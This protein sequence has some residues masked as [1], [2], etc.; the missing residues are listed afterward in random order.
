MH[1]RSSFLFSSQAPCSRPLWAPGG[2][3]T[4]LTVVRPLDSCAVEPLELPHFPPMPT[5]PVPARIAIAAAMVLLGVSGADAGDILRGGTPLGGRSGGGKGTAGPVNAAAEAARINAKDAL[6]RTT[7]A[8]ASVRAMQNAARTAALKAP[9]NL[10]INP[11]IPGRPLPN[12]ADGLAENGLKVAAGVPRK[13]G[14]PKAG[15]DPKLWRGAALPT[16]SKRDGRVNVTVFQTSSQ[17]V[18][19]WETFNVGKKT[20]L[21]FNQDRGGADKTQWTAFNK[22]ADPSGAPSQILGKIE[23]PGQVYVINPNG[24]MFGGSAQINL[25]GLVASSLP[26]NEGLI[27]RGLLSN[28]DSQFLF[29]A[30]PQAAGKNGTPAHTPV[31]SLA[32]GGKYGDVVVQKGAQISAPSSSNVGGR[33][34][35]VGPNVK[36]EGTISTPDGQT[37][38]AAGLQV[39]ITAHPSSDARLRGLD[40]WVGAVNV[41]K[42]AA[43]DAPPIIPAQN[44]AGTAT[45][46]GLIEAARGNTTIAGRTVNQLGAI[47]SSTS[48]SVNGS[49][50]LHANFAAT[51]IAPVNGDA[52][53]SH[54]NT[55]TVTM[56]DDSVQ[57]I[58]PELFNE[59]TVIGLE[60]S[61]R[62]RVTVQGRNI[63]MGR[64]STLLAP[65]ADVT[66]AAGQWLTVG[67]SRQFFSST[68]QIYLDSGAL[69]NVAGTTDVVVP[70]SQNILSLELRGAELAD[71]PLQRRG[72]LRGP[73]LN[74]DIRQR[75]NYN[76]IDWVGTP[77]GNAVGYVGLIERNVGELTT[78]GGTVSMNAGNSVVIQKGAKVDVSG[79]YVNFEGGTVATTRIISDGRVVDIANALPDRVHTRLYD[80]AFTVANPKYG[81]E[82]TFEHPLAL[83]GEHFEPGYIEGKNAGSV[84][85]TAPS[86]VLDGELVGKTISG[87][88]QRTAALAPKLGA[89]ALTF[90]KPDAGIVNYR[91][92]SPTPPA[93]SFGT[94]SLPEA[95]AFSVNAAG[96]APLLDPAR[97][98]KVILPQDLFTNFGSVTINNGDGTLEVPEETKLKLQP[99]GTFA[100]TASNIEIRSDI[101]APGGTLNFTALKITPYLD[102]LLNDNQRSFLIRDFD[103]TRGRFYLEKGVRLDVAGLVV[104]DR[105]LSSEPLS[106]PIATDGGNISI[107]GFKVD[108]EKGSVLDASGGVVFDRSG[109]RTYG[110]GGSISI[111]GG[112]DPRLAH[113]LNGYVI[114]ERVTDPDPTDNVIPP[115]RTFT[116]SGAG[117]NLGA[118]LRAFSGGRGG[119][120][121]IQA[122][123]I[124][125]G[126]ETP[127]AETTLALTPEFFSKGGF[128]SFSLTGLGEPLKDG[129]AAGITVAPGTIIKPTAKSTLAVPYG[130]SREGAE[131]MEIL[132]P[133]ALRTPVSITLRAPG[134]RDSGTLVTRGDVVIGRGATIETDPRGAITIAGETVD[135][136]GSL[137]APAGVISV[138]GSSNPGV[139]FNDSGKS[140]TSV[141]IG[142]DAVLSAKGTT[143]YT[144]NPF[145]FR[146]GSVLPGGR[147]SVSGNIVAEAG[148]ILDVSGATGILDLAPAFVNP[149]PEVSFTSVVPMNSGVNAPLY[150]QT[151]VPT[152]V[153]S[154]AGEIVIAGGQHLF[155]DATLLGKAGGP[156]ALGGALTIS[157]GRFY[158]AGVISNPTDVTLKVTQARPTIPVGGSPAIGQAVSSASGVGH[159]A[160][161]SFARGGFDSLTLRG[162]V[163]FLGP[164]K[165]DARRTLTVADSGV[166]YANDAVTLKAPYITLGTPFKP[167]LTE[168]QV[169]VPYLD[170]NGQPYKFSP[171]SGTGS[172]TVIGNLIDIGNLAL[173]N[174]GKTSF[175]AD[176]GDIRGNGTLNAA[177]DIHFRAGQIYTPTS[178]TF[179]IAA[180]DYKLG[181]ETIR[182]SVVIEGSGNR[183]IPLSAGGTLNVYASNIVQGGALRVPLGSINI[184]WNGDGTAPINPVT[185]EAFAKAEKITLAPG[186]ITS[187]SAISPVEGAPLVIPFGINVNG[188]TWIDPSGRDITAGGVVQ[189]SVNISGVN[190]D[191]QTGSLIDIRGGGDLFA[192][193][194]V[195]GNGGSRDILASTTTFAVLPGYSNHYAPYSP[196]STGDAT[197]GFVNSTLRVGDC[198]FLSGTPT[199]AEGNYTLLPARY[200]MMPGAHLV[201]LKSGTPIGKLAMPDG[202]MLVPGYR[203]NDLNA[204]RTLAPQYAWFEV[205]SPDVVAS[206][207]EYAGYLGN[208]FLFSG[209]A[210]VE[211]RIP[212][213]ASDAGQLTLQAVN[214]M[215]LSGRVAAGAPARSRGGIVDIA[216]PVDIIISGAGAA[217]TAGKLT[218][219]AGQLSSFGAES[220]LIGGIRKV[221]GDGTANITVKTNN[222]TVNNAGTALRGPEIILVANRALTLADGAIVQQR[223]TMRSPADRLVLGTAGTPGSGDGTLLRVTSDANAQIVRNGISTST[224]PNMVV[225]AGATISGVNV[226]LDSTFGTSLDPQAVINAGIVSLNSGQISIQLDNPGTLNPTTGLVL[227]GTALRSLEKSGSVSLLSY[228]TLD[229]YG[230]GKF[231][232][233]GKLAIHTGAIRGFNN[234]GGTATISAGALSLDNSANAIIPAAGAMS[235]TLELRAGTVSIGKG[236][237]AL[238][239]FADVV[240]TASGGIS[241][242]NTGSLSAQGDLTIRTPI[243]TAT[244]SATHAI[245]ASGD[246]VLEEA[247][248]A[249]VTGGLG[250]SLT[251]EGATV[252]ASSDI[253]LPSGLLNVRATSGDVNL[254]GRV[255]LNGTA[256]TFYDLTRYTSG[257]TARFFADNGN[258]RIGTDSV[259]SVS[260]PAEG[261]NAGSLVISAPKGSFTNAGQFFGRAGRD[262]RAGSFSFDA[263]GLADFDSLETSLVEGGFTESQ[264]FR[265][266]AGDVTIGG[267]AKAGHFSLSAD[268]GQITI[269]GNID[270]SGMRG[271]NISL[272]AGGSVILA[273]GSELSVKGQEFDAAGKGGRIALE[274]R[275]LNGGVV[276]IQAGATLNLGVEANTATSAESGNFTGTLHLRAP[277]NSASTDLAVA[278]IGGSING[279]SVILVE[280][281][282]AFD[283]GASG[284]ISTTVQNSVLANGNAFIGTNGSAS[285]SYNAMLARV[286][287]SNTA[288]DPILSI[289]AGAELFNATGNITLGTSTSTTTSDWNLASY[290]FGPD[291]APGILTLRAAGNIVLFNTISDGFQTSAYNSA[292]LAQ[293]STQPVNAQSWSYRFTAGADLTAADY[294]RVQA[295]N[296]LAL[297]SGSLLLGKNGG[298]G[299][300]VTPGA[301]ALTSAA[302]GNRYQAI[303]TGSGDITINAARDVQLLNQFSVIFTAGTQ[304]ADATMGGRFDVP[305]LNAA[306]SADLGVVQQN[307]AA[308]VQYTLAGG[309]VSINAG[310][311]IA[312]YTRIGNG[313]LIAD[314]SRQMPT[315][316]LYRRGFI[317]PI[318][319]EFGNGRFGDNATTTWWVDFANFFEG[320]GALGGGNVT[321]DAGRNVANVDAVA[322]TNARLA[323]GT[324][325]A[326][327]LVELGGGDVTV[328][329]GN[330]ID[331]G[332]YYVER[333]RG[334]L[335]AGGSIKTNNTRSPSLTILKSPADYL[336][337]QTWLPTTL[338]VGKSTFDVSARGDL[339]LG[340]AANP[341]LMPGGFNN[342]YWYK[343]YFSTYGEASGVS[344]TSLSGDVTMR[345][346]A[347]DS[348]V[349]N[350]TPLLLTWYK[351]ELLLSGS[352]SAS[353]YQ[354]WLRLN[355]TNVTPFATA[356]SLMP[357]TL[358]AT[359]FS[360]DI[361]VVGNITLS[362]SSKGN[363]T[364]AASGS[365][366]GLN[367]TGFKPVNNIS[368]AA[369]G[370]ARINLSDANPDAIPGIFSPSAFQASVGTIQGQAR[371]TGANIF[372]SFDTLFAESGSTRSVLQTKQALH[373]PGVLHAGD[374][375]PLRIYAGDGDIQGITLFSPKVAQVYAGRDIADVALYIQNTSGKDVSII[376]AGRDINPYSANT[377]TRV[378]ANSAGNIVNPDSVPLAGDIQISGPGALEVLA[379]RNIDLGTGRP[380]GDGTGLGIVSIGNAR[381]PFLPFD[382]A[383]L[384][385]GAGLGP[386][387]GLSASAL[388]FATFAEDVFTNPRYAEA[389]AASLGTT[390]DIDDLSE[391]QRNLLAMELFYYT[392][393]DSGRDRNDPASAD[394]GTYAG[395]FEAIEKLFPG[396][397]WKGDVSLT[398]RQIKTTQGGDVSIFT[399]GGK[400]IVGFDAG[401]GQSLDQG[402]LTE[403][404]GN[405]HIFADGSVTLGTSRIFTLRGGNEII[406]SS[407]GDIAAGTSSKTV[408][409]APPTRVLIDPQSADLKTDL[410]GLATGGGIGVLTTVEGIPPGDV[411]LIAP[412][413]A[414]D[415]GDAGIRSAGNLNVAADVVLNAE[416]IQVSGS[417]AGAPGGAA[418][419]APS[420]PAAPPPPQP[421]DSNQSTQAAAPEK[422]REE[423]EKKKKAEE[424]PSIIVVEV[425][426]YGG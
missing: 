77:L 403:S 14:A 19:N 154:D 218:L 141:H 252:T 397:A 349:N 34:M 122:P 396:T 251:L 330:D 105:P 107:A 357:G 420:I 335:S 97:L 284:A 315:N 186:S 309:N 52:F 294:S 341:F 288:L 68:G 382:G 12:V 59:K 27:T 290:R 224:T 401:A 18:L 82:K 128:T 21:T 234:D 22:V 323:K 90:E 311:D 89:L 118:E 204:Q 263:A 285:S 388:D 198:V 237:L 283:L 195:Q 366:N 232:V 182:G 325:S 100:V 334:V 267:T 25:H 179:T 161:N 361:N 199:L 133:Q 76:G 215:N 379:G 64:D 32:P 9:N 91:P 148:S 194:W 270:A 31:A 47:D 61:L 364:L 197:A 404:G 80:G 10:G 214:S 319:G 279:A 339:L 72:P 310:N 412:N 399:P 362:P 57:Q 106:M 153:D 418:P 189:K 139:A 242:R 356:A 58:L 351:N 86:M 152:N 415:A 177:G 421:A 45:N 292:L 271:G 209:A 321:L 137:L 231:N 157:S 406:W 419:A 50:N 127:T 355:E 75:G 28:P 171:T 313:P 378:L 55:G 352:A 238:Q 172:L 216:S 227:G 123:A 110:A 222:L 344:A 353:F 268:S 173:R 305:I 92:H 346:S 376:S 262:G 226:T 256:Q 247:G 337:E 193:R 67:N 230:T 299:V 345:L 35:L 33:V 327:N 138:S 347:T 114:R 306:G 71:S 423:E 304:V 354:P 359:A 156:S 322:P 16:Q 405:I 99:R 174:I 387:G 326:D 314:S 56:G 94:G 1:T 272:S 333:G 155:T 159:F 13:L 26:I 369:W 51:V 60:L 235:G 342:T 36:N 66:F 48:V 298:N 42:P 300:F 111:R 241:A 184:G 129:F 151:L 374:A 260:A 253:L 239:Q 358:S 103:I 295:T 81:V 307:P 158:E 183:Q 367:L 373:S 70:V 383:D 62:S 274:T 302:I 6:A 134:V 338:F 221:N 143:L 205:L 386:S 112:N 258:I 43:P 316:W 289:R 150:T 240:I 318:T 350:A 402:I 140:L 98:A 255:N 120:L 257:G 266:R 411:D 261:G 380:P 7:Q 417:T 188:V 276:D 413:G 409:S 291:A 233:A 390:G 121:T 303:R 287:G 144:P 332:V 124:Q 200:A 384:F 340:P 424:P 210:S 336:P 393:R 5:A 41:P 63:L 160:A 329:A 4:A 69:L 408:A 228:T 213:L 211:A 101:T 196:F 324:P 407:N 163:E 223:G 212:R 370:A 389:I 275:G 293:S 296:S 164:V 422:T 109:R 201:T 113:F 425:L 53:F 207:A 208:E 236:N 368:T 243:V 104:D 244:R 277:Q 297:D 17:A 280:G 371:V 250:A 40:V 83:S 312:H 246:L 392:L 365:V 375:A 88:R 273:S 202:S 176:N 30:L 414:I 426:G 348:S 254:N 372:T 301:N 125:I 24:I 147:I 78:S 93:I 119:A 248:A 136:E 259:I 169:D 331:G 343:T 44:P 317:D 217:K 11:N 162:T 191:S 391:E 282:K 360:G 115:D 54:T 190:V 96:D 192:Y 132:Q 416:N 85:I 2:Y 166:L 102:H 23:A 245:K 286:L 320:V 410:A 170:G 135:L 87:P 3:I 381:N 29:S 265:I 165:I 117:L 264:S 130:P 181:D 142:P 168:G 220:L 203:F 269:A 377:Q 84:N 167:P 73:T 79:G 219:D 281:Y 400:I 146:T 131:M 46:S 149:G 20:T 180:S 229:L 38:L 15:E 108:L 116:V 175:V 225:G 178:S 278:T 206:R 95:A 398:A 126:G 395:G 145:G 187:V 185:G 49:I 8:L 385:V 39:G 363:L 65:N 37:I 249:K 394:F 74:L 308:P 328:R